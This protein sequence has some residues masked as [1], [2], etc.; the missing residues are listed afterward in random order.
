MFILQKIIKPSAAFEKGKKKS[1]KQMGARS[2]LIILFGVI[3]RTEGLES[4][5]GTDTGHPDL[6]R[7]SFSVTLISLLL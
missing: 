2:A 1:F 7:D 4:E 5:H 3:G 6:L